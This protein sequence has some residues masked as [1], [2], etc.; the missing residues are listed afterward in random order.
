MNKK[1]RKKRKKTLD[2]RFRKCYNESVK[3]KKTEAR[4]PQK[5]SKKKEKKGLDKRKRMCYNKGVKRK[6]TSD[7]KK[8]GGTPNS[9]KGS[10]YGKHC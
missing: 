3:R 9:Q 7:N 10:H 8:E 4:K 5:K 2:N 1:N 6:E